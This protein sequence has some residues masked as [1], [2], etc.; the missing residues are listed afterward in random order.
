MQSRRK[1]DFQSLQLHTFQPNHRK[2]SHTV[3][4]SQDFFEDDPNYQEIDIPED[5][6]LNLPSTRI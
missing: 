4:F 5:H 1:P 3:S 2:R 6:I